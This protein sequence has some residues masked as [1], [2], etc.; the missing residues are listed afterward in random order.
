[1]KILSTFLM[2]LS[3]SMAYGQ[4]I[5]SYDFGK[6]KS[7]HEITDLA[8]GKLKLGKGYL[9]GDFRGIDG[10]DY[11]RIWNNKLIFKDTDGKICYKTKKIALR[12]TT[13]VGFKVDIKGTGTLDKNPNKS[14]YDWV[15]ISY[16][17]DGTQVSFE[18]VNP[19]NFEKR[20]HY[21]EG[22]PQNF[23]S[24]DI[25]ITDEKHIE[26]MFCVLNTGDDE[27][28]LFENFKIWKENSDADNKQQAVVADP[29]LDLSPKMSYNDEIAV[30][31]NPSSDWL[32]IRDESLFNLSSIVIY[33]ESG[34]PVKK[35]PSYPIN[36]SDL[37]SG[38]YYLMVECIRTK[39]Q[40]TIPFA[41]IKK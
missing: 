4:N 14:I 26:I 2:I 38:N 8:N 24:R 29:K 30:F 39:E 21:I 35:K 40:V 25:T 33:N 13:S 23:N 9:T 6:N 22:V 20:Q 41:F 12:N 10:N 31:P 3:F 17:L 19:E 18:S 1:M 11:I 32:K 5:T 34:M 7:L 27:T 15:D 28:Y 36:L 37:S 16:F